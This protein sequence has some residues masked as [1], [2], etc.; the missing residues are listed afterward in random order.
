MNGYPQYPIEILASSNAIEINEA[1]SH[2]RPL[3]SMFRSSNGRLNEDF[4]ADVTLVPEPDNPRDKHAISVRWWDYVIGYLPASA[5]KDYAQLRRIAASGYDARVKARVKAREDRDGARR[6]NVRVMLPAP[7]LLVPLNNPPA[8]GFALLPV[9]NKIQV[10]K[11]ADHLDY[12]A[13]FVAPEGEGQILVSLHIFEAGKDKKWKCV[14]VRLEGQR[15]GELTK[16]SSE[17]FAPAVEHFAKRGLDLYCRAV[18]TGSSASAEVVLYGA[19][20]H[21]LPVKFLN[22]KSTKPLPRLVDY[23]P[24]ASGYQSLD[25]QNP[26]SSRTIIP[27]PLDKVVELTPSR[28]PTVEAVG[29]FAHKHALSRTPNGTFDAELI[30]EIDNPYDPDAISVRYQGEG[31]AYIPRGLTHLY[32]QPVAKVIASGAIPVVKAKKYRGPDRADE[33]KLYLPSGEGALPPEYQ[34]LSNIDGSQIAGYFRKRTPVFQ[35]R[36]QSDSNLGAI[37]CGLILLVLLIIAIF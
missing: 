16:T 23:Q 25:N 4:Y 20:A 6:Y 19:K 17:K 34:N 1:Q 33:V 5:C 37:G 36:A 13:D 7:E 11:E 12:L 9:G 10:T 3:G 18:I 8:D 35:R 28:F 24:D 27:L 30:P 32:W 15:I 21:E 29:E 2:P 22:T 31:I 26:E 14:E